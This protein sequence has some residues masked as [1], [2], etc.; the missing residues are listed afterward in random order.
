MLATL[1]PRKD[2]EL[3]LVFDGPRFYLLA[4]LCCF[5]VGI[6]DG[7]FGPATG[8]FFIL[9]LHLIVRVHLLQA[10]ATTKV[11]N[12]SSNIGA[13]IVFIISGEVVWS[14]ALCM[15]VGSITGNWMGSRMA[16]R[17]GGVFV[18]RVLIVSLSILMLSLIWTYFIKG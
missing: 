18:Q 11:L 7:F 4:P 17:I 5:V 10:S 13:A 8:S 15:A 16:I 12:L 14:L 1:I 2:K 6:Y 9:A 3:P